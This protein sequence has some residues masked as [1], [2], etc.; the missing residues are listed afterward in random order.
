MGEVRAPELTRLV[1][2]HIG[3][4]AEV[5]V[6]R[7]LSGGANQE[8]WSFDAELAGTTL[9]LIL[10]RTPGG[11]GN[12]VARGAMDGDAG[13]H[14]LL[15]GLVDVLHVVGQ[16]TEVAAAAELF[17]IPVVGQ[18]ELGLGVLAGSEEDQREAAR[19]DIDPAQLLQAEMVAVEAQRLLEIRDPDHG[20]Q[21]SHGKTPILP[22]HPFGVGAV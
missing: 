17:R 3:E 6:L 18:L 21:V 10:R 15:T 11:G 4:A 19:F 13:V 14:Q 20:V 12:P 2:R 7:Q 5:R 9:P 1:K 8:T 22:F 16:V